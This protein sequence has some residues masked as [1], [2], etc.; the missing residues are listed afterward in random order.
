MKKLLIV[1]NNMHIG[2]VQKALIS[3]LWNIRFHYDITLLLFDKV[4]EYCK[5][6]PPEVTVTTPKSAYRFLGMSGSDS[7]SFEDKL[8]RSFFAAITRIFGR[9]YAILLMGIGQKKLCGFDVAISYLH[10]AGNKLFYGGCNDFVLKHVCAGKKIAFLH[11]DYIQSGANTPDN[12]RM[13]ACFDT[14]A[15]CGQGSADSFAHENPA[16]KRKVQVV[17]NCHRF[18]QIQKLATASPVHMHADKLNVVTVARLSK[19]KGVVRAVQAIAQLAGHQNKLHYYVIGDG[20]QREE[21][22]RI[23][24]KEGLSSCVTL[25]G[26]LPN[27]YGYINAA[28]LLLIP[29]YSEASPLVIG[30]AAC[31]GTPI[32]ST[33]TSSARDM[34]EAH[35]YGWVCENSEE[36]IC[37]SLRTL[38]ADRTSLNS[39]RERMKKET[40]TNTVALSQFNSLIS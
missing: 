25:C 31:L 7:H 34:I 3:L 6:I 9:K 37:E 4:G 26:M 11:C 8:G 10:N 12:N 18:D 27:P 1:N 16:L 32:L 14:I 15:A 21:I 13:Y 30:E 5:D 40:I 35:G 24:E 22:M 33:E 20:K 39:V 23:I 28:D 29:S 36:A 38:L 19:E 17:A 2:G